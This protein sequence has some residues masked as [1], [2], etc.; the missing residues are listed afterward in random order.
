M[1]K[2]FRRI[3][4]KLLDQGQLK[5]YLAYALGEMLLVMF[6]ILLAIQ[7]NNFYEKRKNDQYIE[8]LLTALE[9]DLIENIQDTNVVIE[10]G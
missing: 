4:R 7:V 6:G 1:L 9:H 5:S 10:W 2:F 3:R 8:G